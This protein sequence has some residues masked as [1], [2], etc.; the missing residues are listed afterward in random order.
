MVLRIWHELLT[1]I[2]SA[3]SGQSLRSA[4]DLRAVKILLRLLA[5]ILKIFEVAN[6]LSGTVNQANHYNQLNHNVGAEDR[7]ARVR[8]VRGLNPIHDMSLNAPRS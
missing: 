2:D 1:S 6:S 8:Q 7:L 3:A 5:S 4:Q